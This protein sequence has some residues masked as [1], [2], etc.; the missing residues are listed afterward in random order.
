MNI[1]EMQRQFGIQLNQL[2]EALELHSDDIEYWLNKGQL[3]LVK[4]MYNGMNP[5]GKAFEQSQQRIDD[6]RT[7]LVK[8]EE[9]ETTFID[10]E[11]LHGF[12]IDRAEIPEDSLFVISHRSKVSYNFPSINYT[13]D[14]ETNKRISDDL[15]STTR[16][17]FNRTSQSDDIY[18]LLSDPFNRTKPNKPIVDINEDFINVYTDNTFVVDSVIFN[19][20]KKPRKMNIKEGVDSELPDHLHDDII[21]RAADLFLQNTR[22][23]KQRLQQ[24]T[25]R[26][27]QEQNI[28][29]NE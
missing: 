29:N 17:V 28:E 6:L 2:N 14:S 27:N 16:V 11:P 26:S 21:Q 22:Q 13:I 19:Y 9:V 25:P 23:L 10:D 8:D 20:L 18:K 4:Q 3:Q 5:E 1:R 24:E 7:L 15:E 12:F